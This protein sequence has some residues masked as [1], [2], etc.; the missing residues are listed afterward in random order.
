LSETSALI[1]NSVLGCAGGLGVTVYGLREASK[2]PKEE[3]PTFD[4][5]YFGQAIGLI[6]LGGI[7]ALANHLTKPISALTA[8]NLGLSVPAIIKVDAD[9]RARKPRK[10]R[11]D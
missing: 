9:R 1:I 5:L 2:L 6:L 4:R 11:I 10:K 7:V 3:R 8:L